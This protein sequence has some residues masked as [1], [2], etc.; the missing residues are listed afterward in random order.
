METPFTPS[1]AQTLFLS[2][3]Q[4]KPLNLCTLEIQMP[5]LY[6]PASSSM[7][8]LLPRAQLLATPW[9][10]RNKETLRGTWN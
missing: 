1:T 10:R 8:G 5:W 3:L 2:G 9:L 7:P 6:E 4:T